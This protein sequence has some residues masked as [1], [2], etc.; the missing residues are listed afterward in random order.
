ML[1]YNKYVMFEQGAQ[2]SM[3]S[4]CVLFY[5]QNVLR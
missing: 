3:L 2:M 5:K 1:L 4:E